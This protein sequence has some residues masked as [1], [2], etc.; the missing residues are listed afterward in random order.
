MD[1]FGSPFRI[2]RCPQCEVPLKREN[3]G[4]PEATAFL[5]LMWAVAGGVTLFVLAILGLVA[6]DAWFDR[7]GA[8]I[9][10]CTPIIA[11]LVLW[12]YVHGVRNE[13][14][15]YRCPKCFVKYVV[16]D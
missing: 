10:V 8:W 13:E 3:G 15:D 2:P 7:Y 14:P 4:P 12:R 9:L 5:I 16:N 11:L 1:L 6:P